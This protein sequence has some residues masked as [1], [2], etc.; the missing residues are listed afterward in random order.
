LVHGVFLVTRHPGDVLV[1][2]GA[3]VDA[4]GGADEQVAAAHG[5]A[6]DGDHQVDV[7]GLDPRRRPLPGD[8]GRGGGVAEQVELPSPRPLAGGHGDHHHDDRAS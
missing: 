8:H 3:G 7:V 6:S 4:F 2:V 5:V 1:G